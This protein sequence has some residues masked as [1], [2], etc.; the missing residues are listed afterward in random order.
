MKLQGF[1]LKWLSECSCYSI[2]HQCKGCMNNLYLN[3][4]PSST[5]F[6]QETAEKHLNLRAVA[7]SYIPALRSGTVASSA[8]A[9]SLYLPCHKVLE[10]V[11][12]YRE[13]G[14][15]Q[16]LCMKPLDHSALSWIGR[17]ERQIYEGMAVKQQQTTNENWGK[18]LPHKMSPV[19]NIPPASRTSS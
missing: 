16:K 14:R 5:C 13:Q 4:S 10:D 8:A 11:P 6:S 7:K 9:S 15:D 12:S 18:K 3:W 19:V 2:K 1:S 17:W